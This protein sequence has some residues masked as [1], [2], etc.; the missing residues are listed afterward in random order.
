MLALL[1]CLEG[2]H[3]RGLLTSVLS[4]A[5]EKEGINLREGEA[6]LLCDDV[7]VFEAGAGV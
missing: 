3:R 1:G 4:A 6:E 7:G 2:Q 5:F